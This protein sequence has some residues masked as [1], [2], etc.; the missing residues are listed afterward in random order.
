MGRYRR[1]WDTYR[2]AGFSPRHAVFGIFGEPRAR[3]VGLV[4]RGKKRL[5]ERAGLF[6][7]RSTT[8][9]FEGYGIC[10]A[11]TCA[12]TWMWRCAGYPAEGARK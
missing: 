9:R 7:N 1:L 8:E 11:E 3:V 6:I 4:R 2:F 12:S 5:A 10:R